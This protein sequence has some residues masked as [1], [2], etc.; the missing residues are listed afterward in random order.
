MVVAPLNKC[1]GVSD[2]LWFVWKKSNI[3]KKHKLTKLSFCSF[4]FCKMSTFCFTK[5]AVDHIGRVKIYASTDSR[6]DWSFVEN[7]I[8]I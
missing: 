8:Y 5:Q 6:F 2:K 1:M 3:Y 7:Y 4:L